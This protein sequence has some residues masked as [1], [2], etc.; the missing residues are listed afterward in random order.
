MFI[1]CIDYFGLVEF[2]LEK[3]AFTHRSTIGSLSRLD[4]LLVSTSWVEKF[5]THIESVEGFL[6]SDHRMIVLQGT[7]RFN[8]HLPFRFELF[9]FEKPA[10]LQLMGQWW[11]ESVAT[12]NPGFDM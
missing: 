7:Y 10:L 5:G 3:V 11:N 12:G 9:R 6:L 8:G 2:D 4:S 1:D